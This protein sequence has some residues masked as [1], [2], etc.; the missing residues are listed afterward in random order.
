MRERGGFWVGLFAS[1][2]YPFTW[3]FSR[4]T[5]RGMENLPKQ[6]PALLVLNHPSYIDPIVDAIFV[7]QH[8]RVPRFFTKHTLWN[9][10]LLGRVLDGAGQIPVYRGTAK[11]GDSLRGADDSLRMGRVVVFYPEGTLTQDPD[12]WPTQVKTG[13]ARVALANDVPVIP[14][15]RWGTREIFDSRRKKFRPFPRKRVDLVVGAPIDLSAYRDKDIDGVLL[16]EVTEVI[17]DRVRE[18]LKELRA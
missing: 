10:P 15:A 18:L 7:H 4:R 13:I 5:T 16:R 6:G 17:M 1:V 11:A 12:G 14:A 2:F 9:I 8:G 3:A